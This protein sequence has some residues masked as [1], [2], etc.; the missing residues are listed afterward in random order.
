[1]PIHHDRTVLVIPQPG[2]TNSIRAQAQKGSV[3]RNNTCPAEQQ[4]NPNTFILHSFKVLDPFQLEVWALLLATIAVTAMLSLWFSARG[5]RRGGQLDHARTIRATV[6][7]RLAIDEFLSKGIFFCSAGV[8]QDLGAS[9]PQKLLMFGFAFFVLI[10]VSAY[11]ANLAA[12][13]TRNV[14]NDVGTIE[15]VVRSGKNI[16]AHPALEDDLVLAHPDANFIFNK[17]GKELFGLVEDYDLGRCGVMA[18]GKMDSLGDLKLM[19]LFC[20]RNLVFTE[21]LIIENPVGF[22]IRSELGRYF[23]CYFQVS[24]LACAHTKYVVPT[25][26]Q[27]RGFHTGCIKERNT[28]GSMFNLYRRRTKQRTK[29]SPVA[30]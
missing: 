19:E 27:L 30:L 29:E 13:L 12:F 8:E 1:M 2:S 11:V 16:C 7:A 28:M 17:E 21:S 15:E 18:V 4:S 10:V 5:K 14:H 25:F 24:P 6:L 20:E 22:P 3:S 9:L 26:R 23:C